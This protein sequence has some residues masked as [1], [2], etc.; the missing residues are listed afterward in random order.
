[1]RAI[2]MMNKSWYPSIGFSSMQTFAFF[3]KNILHVLILYLSTV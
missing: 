1:M 2:L 3:I